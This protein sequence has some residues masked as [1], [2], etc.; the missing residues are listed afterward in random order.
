M[1]DVI[2]IC[3]ISAGARRPARG[4]EVSTAE[5]YRAEF[6]GIYL[7]NRYRYGTTLYKQTSTGHHINIYYDEPEPRGGATSDVLYC[8]R[9]Y[10]PKKFDEYFDIGKCTWTAVPAIFRK[11]S[12]GI[13]SPTNIL[14][15]RPRGQAFLRLLSPAGAGRRPGSAW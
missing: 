7:N 3:K 10:R 14:P 11:L 2:G 9:H 8:R 5:L 15:L 6:A 4:R 1:R 13:I 12:S